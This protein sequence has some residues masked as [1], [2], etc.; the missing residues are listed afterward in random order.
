MR[1]DSLRDLYVN[2]TTTPVFYLSSRITYNMRG[3]Q[4]AVNAHINL[5][6]CV[7]VREI[8]A[9]ATF[10]WM[11]PCDKITW[12]LKLESVSVEMTNKHRWGDD[13]WLRGERNRKQ[14]KVRRWICWPRELQASGCSVYSIE[15]VG[16]N[17]F[18]KEPCTHKSSI[19]I[20][21]GLLLNINWSASK[22][23]TGMCE[24]V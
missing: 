6:L 17:F 2:M 14:K 1:N 10:F 21:A 7:C 12:K 20:L 3:M 13:V 18:A 24:F 9:M 22:R 23:W 4:T 11:V 5:R 19:N 8:W 16:S 15:G